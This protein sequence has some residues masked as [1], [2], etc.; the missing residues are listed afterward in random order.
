M[1]DI[2]ELRM[3]QIGE[4]IRQ[5]RKAAKLTQD[6]LAA[7]I[8]ILLSAEDQGDGVNQSAVS[9][10]ETGNQ[11]PP[12]KRLIALSEIFKCDIAYLL[13]DYDEKNKNVSDISNITGLAEDSIYFLI[14]L[15]EAKTLESENCK[16]ALKSLLSE[17]R[18]DECFKFW[19]RIGVFLFNSDA[20]FNGPVGGTYRQFNAEDVLSILLSENEQLLR[21]IRREGVQNG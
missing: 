8:T 13:C 18:Y 10:W 5:C 11:L 17:S 21:K 20:P 4:R 16:K 6:Q 1:T 12:I 15:N 2:T 9:A 3:R 19:E 14:A 7:K